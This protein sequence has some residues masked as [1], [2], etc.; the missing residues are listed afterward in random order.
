MKNYKYHLIYRILEHNVGIDREQVW[1]ERKQQQQG[2]N[3]R[4]VVRHRG[5]S[6]VVVVRKWGREQLQVRI[7]EGEGIVLVGTGHMDR[8]RIAEVGVHRNLAVLGVGYIAVEEVVVV[9]V[10]DGQLGRHKDRMAFW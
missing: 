9:V 3:Q 1:V 6:I 8:E 4:K 7:V 10:V 2:R 5:S